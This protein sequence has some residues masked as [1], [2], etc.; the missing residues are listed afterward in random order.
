MSLARKA[1]SGGLWMA[2]L[3]YVTFTVSFL[4][5][6]ALARLLTPDDFGVVALAL[7][8]S[9]ILFMLGGFGL[10]MGCIHLQEEADVFDTGMC[11]A[12]MLTG[13]MVILGVFLSIGLLWFYPSRIVAFV[14]ILC[15]VK[16]FQFPS[17]IYSSYMEKDFLFGRVTLITGA[18]TITAL[19]AALF[20]AC[21]GFGEWS[22]LSRHV[23]LI[24]LTFVGMA[25]ASPY[26][27]RWRFN[28]ETA[29][30]LWHY[31]YRMF[32]MRMSEV[33]FTQLPNFLL[34]SLVGTR[35]LGL[36]ERTYFLSMAPNSVFAPLNMKVAFTVYS[37]I[38]RQQEKI[39]KGIFWNLM[40]TVRVM[41]PAGLI[42]FLFPELILK[43]LYGV[44][45][46]VAAPLLRGF[47]LYLTCMPIW[48]V[49]K[50]VLLAQGHVG[51]VT[52]GRLIGLM[53]ILSWIALCLL[54]ERYWQYIPWAVSFGILLGVFWLSVSLKKRATHIA[55][56]RVLLLPG[57]SAFIFLIFFWVLSFLH[58]SDFIKIG[59]FLCF[60]LI[61]HWFIERKSFLLLFEDIRH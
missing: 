44:K 50:H 15:T 8:I 14:I 17:S 58:V 27:F 39:E 19:I 5:N 61:S 3:S 6:I 10:S 23:V 54:N 51:D 48:A 12:W 40:I 38:K 13:A 24:A 16:A 47:A 18:A 33:A 25:L 36:Y 11:L 21:L 52:R 29:G 30:K 2:G 31:A 34:G 57:L 22:L 20:M 55:W 37:K 7:S 60:W 59:G 46:I 42:V 53:T 32:F 41:L 49:L 4:G 45:W 56:I 43:T 26:R 35:F 9:E 1:A 28:R